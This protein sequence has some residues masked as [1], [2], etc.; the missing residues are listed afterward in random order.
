VLSSATPAI[1]EVQ[2]EDPAAWLKKI[3]TRAPVQTTLVRNSR[4]Q[5]SLGTVSREAENSETTHKSRSADMS[6]MFGI[7]GKKKLSIWIGGRCRLRHDGRPAAIWQ[8]E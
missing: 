5:K 6:F 4:D 8:R 1:E 2:C 7:E 3:R